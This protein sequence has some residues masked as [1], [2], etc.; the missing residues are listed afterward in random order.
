MLLRFKSVGAKKLETTGGLC[1]VETSIRALQELEDV[2]DDD[3]FQI[4]LVLVVQVLRAQL[5]LVKKRRVKT[6]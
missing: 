1:R 5:D 3:S 2:V 6:P 4:D